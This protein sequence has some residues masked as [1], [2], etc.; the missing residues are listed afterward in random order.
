M[1]GPSC[2]ASTSSRRPVLR[3][4]TKIWNESLLPAH[5]TCGEDGQQA[6]KAREG[7]FVSAPHTEACTAEL[8]QQQ[9]TAPTHLPRWVARQGDELDGVGGGQGAEVAVPHQVKGANGTV[10]AGAQH[11][12]PAVEGGGQEVGDAAGVSDWGM[13]RA[14]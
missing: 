1:T 12:V 8:L 11:G 7:C 5:T 4:H 3:D 2:A 13:L 10:Q 6:M 14:G 9:C